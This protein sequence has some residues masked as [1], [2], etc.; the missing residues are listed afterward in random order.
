MGGKSL[1]HKCGRALI[2]KCPQREQVSWELESHNL[3]QHLRGFLQNQIHQSC[4]EPTKQY[5]LCKEH[6]RL[7]RSV[8][9]WQ[10]EAQRNYHTP[11]RTGITKK[12]I[13]QR[14]ST[15]GALQLKG[16]RWRAYTAPAVGNHP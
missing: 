1:V 8:S 4:K 12:V 3:E 5:S 9:T 7:S 14:R 16:Y 2:I 10:A 15:A 13:H 6:D 11:F